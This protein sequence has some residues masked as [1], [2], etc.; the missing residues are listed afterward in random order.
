[1][2]IKYLGSGNHHYDM[3]GNMCWYVLGSR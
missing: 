3:L 2:V 1:M